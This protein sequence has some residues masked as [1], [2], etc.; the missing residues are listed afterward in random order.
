VV[1]GSS[2][3]ERALKSVLGM[4]NKIGGIMRIINFTFTDS[5]TRTL[6]DT[7]YNSLEYS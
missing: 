4:Q 2:K 3:T 6:N 7:F 5:G 1:K